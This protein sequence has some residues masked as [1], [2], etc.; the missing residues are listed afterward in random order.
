MVMTACA[1]LPTPAEG[2][3]NRNPRYCLRC[4]RPRDVGW[5]ASSVGLLVLLAVV[6]VFFFFF[7]VVACGLLPSLYFQL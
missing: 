5:L 6:C 4:C 3:V 2:W 1:K 7:L